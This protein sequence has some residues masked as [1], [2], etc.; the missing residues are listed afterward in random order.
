MYHRNYTNGDV[1][2]ITLRY[3]HEHIQKFVVGLPQLSRFKGLLNDNDNMPQMRNCIVRAV[4][5][6]NANCMNV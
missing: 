5:V 6:N 1:N 3:N 2:L 4:A